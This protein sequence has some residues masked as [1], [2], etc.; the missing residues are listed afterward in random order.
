[1]KKDK[2]KWKDRWKEWDLLAD[3]RCRRAVLYF[4]STT[5]VGRRVPGVDEDG[6]VSAVLSWRCGSGW[7]SRERGPRSRTLGRNRRCYYQRPTSWHLRERSKGVDWATLFLC[8][9]HLFCTLA[10]FP[11]VIFLVRTTHPRDRPRRRAKGVLATNR[12][13]ADSGQETD[14][15]YSRHDLHRSYASNK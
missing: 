11:F 9:Y 4:L 1:V 15:T 5:D 2:G 14:C 7:R 13:C 3:G 6:A 12:H 8:P 10:F